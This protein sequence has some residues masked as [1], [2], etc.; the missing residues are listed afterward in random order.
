M[1]DGVVTKYYF[2][3]GT[4][5]AMR[6]AGTLYYMLSDHLG[7]TGIVTFENGNLLS[8]TK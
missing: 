2:A 5:I 1:T 8:Q 3:G 6:K 4:R 7:S